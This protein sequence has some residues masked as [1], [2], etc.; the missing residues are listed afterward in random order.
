MFLL[1]WAG[2]LTGLHMKLLRAPGKQWL[3]RKA[4]PVFSSNTV[5]T[6]APV[7]SSQPNSMQTINP[8]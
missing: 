2:N 4:E 3:W 5:L 1:K 8:K 6:G 7:P